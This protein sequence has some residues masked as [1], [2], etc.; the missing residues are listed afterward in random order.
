MRTLIDAADADELRR[1]YRSLPPLVWNATNAIKTNAPDQS[2]R[3]S[4]FLRFREQH[5]QVVAAM[6]R[7]AKLVQG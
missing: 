4:E 1:L 5:E 7:I 3:G 2:M 6:A